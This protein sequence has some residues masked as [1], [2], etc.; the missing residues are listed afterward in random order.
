[1]QNPEIRGTEYQEGTLQGWHLRHYILHRDNWTC[2]YC[3]RQATDKNPLT[4]DH[5][6]P[7]S[8]GGPS[9][10]HNLV[11]SCKNCNTK[12]ANQKVSDFLA[13]DSER[14]AKVI[15]QLDQMVPLSSAGRLNSVIPAIRDILEA[16]GLPVTRCDGVTTAFSRKQLGIDKTHVN[17]AACLD[18]PEIVI[19]LHCPVTILKRQGRHKRQSINCDKNGSPHS[20]D[21]PDYSRLP[22]EKQGYS[23][24]PAHSTGPRRR[25]GIRTGDIVKIRQENGQT[26][27]GRAVLHIRQKIVRI[28]QAKSTGD[29]ATAPARTAMLLAHSSRWEVRQNQV[30]SKPSQRTTTKTNTTLPPPLTHPQ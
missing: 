13:K 2:Q 11:T 22:K 30:P 21:F 17:D 25:H 4:L 6:I 14:L 29:D 16:T 3:G 15:H 12:K 1:M 24:P 7:Q 26:F 27:T 28:N 18:L 23:T 19:N 8:K 9:R 20:K 10:V 5:V